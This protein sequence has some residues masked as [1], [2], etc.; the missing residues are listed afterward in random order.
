MS[1]SNLRLILRFK[2]LFDS[3]KHYPC[4]NKK[5]FKLD[6]KNYIFIKSKILLKKLLMWRRSWETGADEVHLQNLAS[7][8]DSNGE[9]SQT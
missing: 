3:F 6:E 8:R 4:V 1:V 5:N 2:S 9:P 7:T